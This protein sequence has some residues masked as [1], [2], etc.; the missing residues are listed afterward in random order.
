VARCAFGR[1]KKRAAQRINNV[2]D[3]DVDV[4]NKQMNNNVGV[5][6][7]FII[8]SSGSCQKM[9]SKGQDVISSSIIQ[10]SM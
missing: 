8:D 3:A 5:I 2:S 6:K 9:L 4:L 1:S 7:W 10:N